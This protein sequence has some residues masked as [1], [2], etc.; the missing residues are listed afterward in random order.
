MRKQR[1]RGAASMSDLPPQYGMDRQFQIYMGGLQGQRPTLPLSYD[2]LEAAAQAVLSPEAFGYVAG[3]AGSEDTMRA[4]REAF[5]RWR[6]IPRLVGNGGVR[7]HPV[8]V[9]GAA[10]AA[11]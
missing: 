5:A 1:A 3:G 10:V 7:R 6:I 8:P 11:A 9:F 4:N 2:A